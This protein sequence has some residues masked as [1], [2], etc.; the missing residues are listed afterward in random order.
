MMTYELENYVDNLIQLALDEDLNVNGDCTTAFILPD[1]DT[2][3]E[4]KIIAKETGILAGVDIAGK[5]FKKIDNDLTLNKLADD[6]QKIGK[7]AIILL[8]K[9]AASSILSAERTALNF[10]QR[11]SGIATLTSKFV[12]AVNGTSAK[13]LDTRKTTPGLRLLEK[14]AVKM[15]G[16]VNH[17]FGLYDMILIKENHIKAANGIPNA[18]A[19]VIAGLK[20]RNMSLEIEV[21]VTNIEELKQVLELPVKRV[22]LD[23]MS[24]ADIKKSVDLIKGKIETEVSGG[25]NL[26]NV[27]QIA[28]TGVDFISVGALTHSAKA[29][30]MSLLIV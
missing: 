15:G 25:V 13:I 21:E 26:N 10:L 9:G 28:E 23:N 17:R 5:V 14:Y 19:M 4:A 18:V 30:D 24:I 27:R 3:C 7:N 29:L 12:E 8:I 16:G 22:L 6:G 20:N 11:L 2:S 1:S